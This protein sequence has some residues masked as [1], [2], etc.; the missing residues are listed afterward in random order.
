MRNLAQ[1]F[2]AFTLL[3]LPALT[4]L[5]QGQEHQH[6]YAVVGENALGVYDT[7]EERL[8]VDS[9]YQSVEIFDT[10][11]FECIF[12]RYWNE[13][14]EVLLNGYVVEIWDS[15]GHVLSR[16]FDFLM[17]YDTP[18]YSTS[19]NYARTMGFKDL[20]ATILFKNGLDLEQSGYRREALKSYV[21]AYRMCPSLSMAKERAGAIQRAMTGE[22]Q[23]AWNQVLQDRAEEA[24]RQAQREASMQAVSATLLSV[25]GAISQV[26]ALHRQAAA[27]KRVQHSSSS[28]NYSSE[29]ESS[30][31]SRRKRVK[32]KLSKN[33]KEAGNRAA[34]NARWDMVENEFIECSL[35]YGGKS[36]H[37]CSGR[38]S[39][40]GVTCTTC[41]G[42]GKC[43]R[44]GGSGVIKNFIL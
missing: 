33:Q 40:N 14:K 6:R 38:G 1:L 35:C 15:H 13:G 18:P 23:A 4:L 19:L 8:V 5:G 27:Q 24:M 16:N 32:D 22:Q 2:S 30:S 26:D 37:F 36:C 41:H 20:E 43:V 3:C 34:E 42:S 10:D 44:C 12:D 7:V 31:D 9:L 17:K 21:S 28:S 39:V 11:I 25:A 29:K